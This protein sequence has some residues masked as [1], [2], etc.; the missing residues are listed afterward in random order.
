[1]KIDLA[2][3]PTWLEAINPRL[4]FDFGKAIPK[5]DESCEIV[6]RYKNG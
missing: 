1:M 5:G 2:L 4:V 6:L 3:L